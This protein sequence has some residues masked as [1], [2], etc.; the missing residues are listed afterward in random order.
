MANVHK[1]DCTSDAYNA[2]QCD[3]NIKNGDLLFIPSEKV[4]G[5]AYTW[6]FAVTKSHGALHTVAN[7]ADGRAVTNEFRRS[8]IE[9]CQ[10]ADDLGF[11][12]LEQYMV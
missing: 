7:N 9:A 3:E 11:E 5:I 4:I 2:V 12:L 1:F 8:M 10:F 6:P